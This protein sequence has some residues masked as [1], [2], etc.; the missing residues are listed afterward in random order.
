MEHFV[1]KKT[2]YKKVVVLAQEVYKCRNYSFRSVVEIQRTL[3]TPVSLLMPTAVLRDELHV[4][5]IPKLFDYFQLGSMLGFC[6]I[7]RGF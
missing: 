2:N 6:S 3:Q 1:T 4:D 7:F 5:L